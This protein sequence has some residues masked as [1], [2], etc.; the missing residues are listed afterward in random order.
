[1][2]S[3]GSEL[4]SPLNFEPAVV[5]GPVKGEVPWLN[6]SVD[7]Y[8]DFDAQDVF[9][10]ASGPKEWQRVKAH[11]VDSDVKTVGSNVTVDE[12]GAPADHAGPGHQH[13]LRRQRHPLRR[14][15]GGSPVW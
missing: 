15:P 7:W 10:A 6:M 14:R 2:R 5:T 1:M 13:L 3:A 11:S 8:T 12:A 4:V 9:L